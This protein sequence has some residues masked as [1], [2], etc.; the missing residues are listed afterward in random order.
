MYHDQI[1][2]DTLLDQVY[3][4]R[5]LDHLPF[6]NIARFG[7]DETTLLTR[8]S[9]LSTFAFDTDGAILNSLGRV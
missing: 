6:V 2:K 3:P 4:F 7:V 8:G 1:A 9:C 5:V